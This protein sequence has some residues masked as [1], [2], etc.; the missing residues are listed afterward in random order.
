ML[1]VLRGGTLI[2]DIG[3]E[4]GDEICH[5]KSATDPEYDSHRHPITIT[6]FTPLAEWFQDSLDESKNMLVNSYHHQ[7]VKELGANLAPMAYA[8]DGVLEGFY[9]TDYAPDAGRYLV[10]LQFHPERMLDDYPGCRRVYESFLTA[11]HAY[12]GQRE[13]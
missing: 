7:G 2:G 4:V 10:G 8:P 9:D 3:T 5:L 6:P 11:C 1:N 12:R 13:S